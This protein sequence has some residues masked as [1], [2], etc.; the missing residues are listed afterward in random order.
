MAIG[1]LTPIAQTGSPDWRP[2]IH[3][4]NLATLRDPNMSDKVYSPAEVAKHADE[5]SGESLPL[6]LASSPDSVPAW[7]IVDDNIVSQP[8]Q[9]RDL[10]RA[11]IPLRIG[12]VGQASIVL[13]AL[14]SQRRPG[15]RRIAK[16][17][18]ASPPRTR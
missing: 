4:A 7:V 14:P 12:W 6:K 18:A 15:G 3:H 8:H 11:L 2:A 16:G 10:C 5:K 9:V 1:T 17:T 13:L